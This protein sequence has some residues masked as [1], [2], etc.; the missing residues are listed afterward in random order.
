MN[1]FQSKNY[2]IGTYEI[3]KNFLSC[4][5]GQSYILDIGIDALALGY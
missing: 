3:D 5:P 1:K 4:F 2:R